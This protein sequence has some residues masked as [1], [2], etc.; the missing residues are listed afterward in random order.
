[1]AAEGAVLEQSPT[2]PR[3]GVSLVADRAAH[4]VDHPETGTRD[5]PW[6]GH[7][8]GAPF[9]ELLALPR[10]VQPIDVAAVAPPTWIGTASLDS[11][12]N[13]AAGCG[14]RLRRWSRQREFLFR[15]GIGFSPGPAQLFDAA[16]APDPGAVVDGAEPAGFL[17]MMMTTAKSSKAIGT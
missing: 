17:L 11:I 4:V 9:G 14:R 7:I 1:M 13:R 8:V 3:D 12:S 2:L 16:V 6:V 10:P 5:D 15:N